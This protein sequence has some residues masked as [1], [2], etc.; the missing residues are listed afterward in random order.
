MSSRNMDPC[1]LKSNA[2]GTSA[3]YI[4]R[5]VIISD[6]LFLFGIS[7]IS[8]ISYVTRLGFYADDWYVLALFK[9]AKD[10][11]LM[12]LLRS[13][14]GLLPKGLGVR[15]LEA[16]YQAC[17]YMIFGL[18]PLPYHLCNILVLSGSA[19]LFYASLREL[20]L[21]RSVTL[22]VPLVYELL[23][24]YAT[25]RFWLGAHQAVIS[26]AFFFLGLYSALTAIRAA[27]GWS[28]CLIAASILSYALA[29]LS[30]EAIVGLLPASVLLVGY[31]TYTQGHGNGDK[32]WA[33][34]LRGATYVLITGACL[35]AILIYKAQFTNRILV[36]SQQA[37]TGHVWASLWNVA[38]VT[39]GFNLL[40]YGARL[41][42]TAFELFRFSG[43][44][45]EIAIIAG[46]IAIFTLLY[47]HRTLKGAKSPLLGATESL[48]LMTVGFVLFMLDYLPFLGL[49]SNFSYEGMDNRVTIAA[50]VGTA[51][52][53]TGGIMLFIRG[54]IPSKLQSLTFCGAIAG[55]CALNYLCIASFGECWAKASSRQHEIVSAVHEKV[56]LAPGSTLLLDGFCRYF[57][58]APVFENAWDAGGALRIAYD[59]TRLQA[60]VVSPSLEIGNDAIRTTFYG[61]TGRYPY[62]QR[63]WMHNVRWNM[64]L[65][66]VDMN[67]ARR[68]F[69]TVNPDKNSGCPLGIEGVGSA[70]R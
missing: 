19:L 69:S 7:L 5:Q 63:L 58:P 14:P 41:P 38:K 65:Q 6:C 56:V 44:G 50:A 66:L 26:Q 59:N 55:I 33:S 42:K 15:P 60:D 52:I 3:Q 70:I 12:G 39:I 40:H 37:A 30:Y 43:F 10:Q 29:L 17:T 4:P 62:D 68:Y 54:V 18:H 51:C 23:P 28:I 13:L 9:G 1:E 46:A 35:A 16:L 49:S 48:V 34:M 21:P 8:G 61:V 2:N 25:D 36:S 27:R 11:S 47:L 67:A 32:R 64:T 45:L 22:T 31:R 20:R 53:L 24:H 57:G